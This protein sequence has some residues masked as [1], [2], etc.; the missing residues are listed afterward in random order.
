MKN[1]DM[2][3][4]VPASKGHWDTVLFLGVRLSAMGLTGANVTI[5]EAANFHFILW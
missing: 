4:K 3:W 1:K 2:N 5:V